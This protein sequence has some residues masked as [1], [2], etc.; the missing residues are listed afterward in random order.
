MKKYL[1]LLMSVIFLMACS[2][3]G[4]EK[5]QQDDSSQETEEDVTESSD[6]GTT[7]IFQN[8]DIRIVNKQK[9]SVTAEAKAT[10]DVIYYKVE[11]DG[12][13]IIEETEVTLEEEWQEFNIS[14]TLPDDVVETEV[15]PVLMLYGKNEA[16]EMVNPN[17]VPIDFIRQSY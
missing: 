7:A 1:L 2:D 5:E 11:H 9:V 16:G 12:K 8:I 13:D 17:Y 3:E 14:I 6:D 10:N 4:A 15:V